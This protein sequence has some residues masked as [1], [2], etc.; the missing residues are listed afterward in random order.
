MSGLS[1]RVFNPLRWLGGHIP[2]NQTQLEVEVKNLIKV[3][4]WLAL[5]APVVIIPAYYLLVAFGVLPPIHLP[6]G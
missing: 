4:F 3:V 2:R 6:S 1:V 5:L